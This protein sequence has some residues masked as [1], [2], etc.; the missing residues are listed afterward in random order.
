M[1]RRALRRLQIRAM[2]R[3]VDARIAV[4]K[5]LATWVHDVAGSDLRVD[6]IPNGVAPDT[7]HLMSRERAR[8]A[9]GWDLHGRYVLA[10]GHMQRLKGFDRLL[11][12]M[13]EVREVLGDVRLI[14]A[15]S[16][17]GERRFRHRVARLVASC[18]T[19][20]RAE[21]GDPS[22]ELAGPPVRFVGPIPAGQLNL[23]YNAADVFV[24]ASRSE[25]WCNAIAESLAAGTPVVATD[26]GGNREQICSSELGTIVADG[27][28][29][30]LTRA[31]I[32]A[33]TREWNRPLISAH[34]SARR[35]THVADEVYAVFA[36]VLAARVAPRRA[37][38][39]F[40]P[41]AEP[42]VM[43]GQRN[44]AAPVSEVAR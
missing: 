8:S 19:R 12:A 37:V 21:S 33:L 43:P 17:R 23:M 2:L 42:E 40:F 16:G 35:W 20:A 26:V 22:R 18:N 39:Q 15:G 7:F 41:L 31:V 3:G 25:G 6:V 10:V 38:Q 14:L 9:L 24:N 34:G 4:S 27:D 36:R 1:S 44:R 29:N 32:A 13:P 11:A 28:R 30:A 5:S